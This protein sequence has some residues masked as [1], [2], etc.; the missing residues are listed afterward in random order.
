MIMKKAVPI[1]LCFV[2][3]GRSFG[4]GIKEKISNAFRILIGSEDFY[5]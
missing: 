5:S 4:T 3:T 2:E 1:K